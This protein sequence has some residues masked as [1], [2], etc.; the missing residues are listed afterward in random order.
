MG[1]VKLFPEAPHNRMLWYSLSRPLR[2]TSCEARPPHWHCSVFCSARRIEL[3]LKQVGNHFSKRM[4]SC[5]TFFMVTHRCSALWWKIFHQNAW[6]LSLPG[7]FQLPI[8]FKAKSP[9]CRFGLFPCRYGKLP[10]TFL[11]PF[12]GRV[13]QVICTWHPNDTSPVLSH[14]VNVW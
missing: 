14:L 3:R 13:F 6:R 8:V 12:D 2:S 10:Q 4:F 5:R 9:Y 1:F 11:P 7:A